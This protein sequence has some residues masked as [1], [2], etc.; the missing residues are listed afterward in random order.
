MQIQNDSE[1]CVE[2]VESRKISCGVPPISYRRL[3]VLHDKKGR[4]IA[5]GRSKV[6]K[7]AFEPRMNVPAK[8]I[9]GFFMLDSKVEFEL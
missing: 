2:P 3:E 5:R 7:S 8:E 6:E 4:L 1:Y 9:Q